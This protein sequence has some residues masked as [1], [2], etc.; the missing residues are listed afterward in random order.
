M[1]RKTKKKKKLPKLYTLYI[2]VPYGKGD[3]NHNTKTI[4][5]KTS[6]LYS[7]AIVQANKYEAAGH[8][9]M[10]FEIVDSKPKLVYRSK[11]LDLD[12]TGIIKPPEGIVIPDKAVFDAQA[13]LDEEREDTEHE[14]DGISESQFASEFGNSEVNKNTQDSTASRNCGHDTEVNDGTRHED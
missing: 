8:S 3:N 4:F 11:F 10:L 5:S 14:T 2:R 6:M 9:V 13:Y 12:G 1:S 7:D